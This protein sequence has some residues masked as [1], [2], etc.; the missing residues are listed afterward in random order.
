[1]SARKIKRRTMARLA[2][3][4]VELRMPEPLASLLSA[5]TSIERDNFIRKGLR[6]YVKARG[7]A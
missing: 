1:M 6:E 5:M 3:P 7:A 2:D 4:R